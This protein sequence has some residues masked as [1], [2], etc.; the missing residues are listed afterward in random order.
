VRRHAPDPDRGELGDHVGDIAAR[1]HAA[2]IAHAEHSKGAGLFL[3][4]L[5]RPEQPLLTRRSQL[6]EPVRGAGFGLGPRPSD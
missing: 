4:V 6:R 1:Q 2:E 3:A 5:E